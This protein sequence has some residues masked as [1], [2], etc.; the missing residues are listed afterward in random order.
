MGA[1]TKISGGRLTAF[2]HEWTPM[3]L[4]VTYFTGSIFFYIIIPPAMHEIVWYI[5]AG[6]QTL[7]SLSVST[8][9]MQSIRPSIKAR[10]DMRRIAKEGWANQLKS[11]QEW[12][13]ID[14]ILV[15]YLPNEQDII[16]RQ[17]RYAL[18]KIDYPHDKLTINVV[19]NTPRPI[20]PVESQMKELEDIHANVRV[21]R[22]PNSTSKADNI[23]YFLTLPSKG[24]IITLYDTDHFADPGALRWVAQRFLSG[25]VDIIQG[26]CNIYNYDETFIT[27]LIGAEFDMIYGVAHSGRA[28]VQG[29]GFFGGSNGHWNASL[30]K[31]LGMQGH[32]LTEDIDSSM[33]AI[34][35]GARIEYDLR[36]LSYEMA[37][38]TLAAF[39]KQ[40]L[41]WAQGWTQVAIRHFTPA[42]K[43]GAYSDGNGWR[44]RMGL[45]QLL[46]Y[47]EIYFYINTQL[48]FILV[49]GIL[50]TLPVDGLHVF[51]KN[52][53]GFSLAMWALAVNIFCLFITSAITMR[54]RGHF[55]K[56]MGVIMFASCTPFYYSYISLMAIYAHFRELCLYS[57][58]NPTARST[59]K[60]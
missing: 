51:F 28:E 33:R 13:L 12:P 46:A 6:L 4:L 25:E 23:N 59:V 40:R 45:L 17:I 8:E 20:E 7:T 16:M 10:R 55:T 15:A 11:G 19:Y 34:I 57:S 32:M 48:L 37:P 54:N 44:S 43:R 39:N 18:T 50:H 30:L 29:Y 49:S 38:E 58:W 22:V 2:V 52:F 3:A 60:K 42:F 9:A 36:V 31:S 5:L 27:R 47:R 24:E 56:P 41:R 53:G 35:S 26:R 1:T 21:I 14:V